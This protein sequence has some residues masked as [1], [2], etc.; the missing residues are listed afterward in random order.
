[1]SCGVGHRH[2]LDWAFLW[3]RYRP[4]AAAPIQPLAWKLPY[5]AHAVLK[6]K[7]NNQTKNPHKTEETEVFPQTEMACWG[8]RITG[9]A[10]P[11]RR[12][13]G[14]KNWPPG[15]FPMTRPNEHHV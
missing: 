11:L 2:S 14:V 12:S 8:V 13:H 3:L 15:L 4:A 5:A 9:S 6:S 10:Q 7:T 1:M